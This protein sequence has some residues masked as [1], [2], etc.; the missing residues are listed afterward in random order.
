MKI[1][2]NKFLNFNSIIFLSV[3][4]GLNTLLNS[5]LVSVRADSSHQHEMN[6]SAE[7]GHD[8]KT[9]DVSNL[10]DNPSIEIEIF[11]D[12]IK[13]WNLYLNTKNFEFISPN[14]ENNNPNQGHAHL[15]ING[16]K[17]S[18]IY[19]NWYYIS[20]LPEAENEIEV[21]LNTNNHHDLI[22]N[23]KIVGDR[24]LINNKK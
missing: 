6:M 7:N 1:S 4:V 15:Y 2:H 12:K 16:V 22:Y 14:L 19:G 21:T 20:E 18:R 17:V 11:P 23:G 24:I 9:L 8:H 13:G 3:F 5:S 10:K